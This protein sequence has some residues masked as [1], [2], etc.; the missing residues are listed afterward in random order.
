[1]AYARAK[2]EHALAPSVANGDYTDARALLY[3]P[4][5]DHSRTHRHDFA[6]IENRNSMIVNVDQGRD[7]CNLTMLERTVVVA[8]GEGLLNRHTQGAECTHALGILAVTI[9]V[10][11]WSWSCVAH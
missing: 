2:L 9:D 8:T 1:M 11:G 4:S 7:G 6:L 3:S 10:R 5:V